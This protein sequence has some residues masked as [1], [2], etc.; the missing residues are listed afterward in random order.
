MVMGYGLPSEF[1]FSAVVLKLLLIIITCYTDFKAYCLMLL[2][3]FN[4]K[5]F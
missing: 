3:D 4:T 2:P 1:V 5:I